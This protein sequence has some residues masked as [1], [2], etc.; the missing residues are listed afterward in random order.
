VVINWS[1]L[2]RF[3]FSD[4]FRASL[5]PVNGTCRKEVAIGILI[6]LPTNNPSATQAPAILQA[7]TMVGAAAGACYNQT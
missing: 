2:D 3:A 4:F 6:K 1:N 7:A 5:K